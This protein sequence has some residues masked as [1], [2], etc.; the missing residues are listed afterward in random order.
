MPFTKSVSPADPMIVERL[1]LLLLLVLLLSL[2]LW[3]DCAKT[4]L[5]AHK[6]AK[7]TQQRPTERSNRAMTA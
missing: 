2:L 6:R 5:G 4:Q 3:L 1:L 7:H